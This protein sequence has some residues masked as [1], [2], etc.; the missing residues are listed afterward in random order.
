MAQKT[1]KMHLMLQLSALSHQAFY[2]A[3]KVVVADKLEA[4]KLGKNL[5]KYV[6]L[7]YLYNCIICLVSCFRAV[8]RDGGCVR[9][10]SR[11]LRL[12]NK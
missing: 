5:L 3:N 8:R 4:L 10:I 9:E 12:K 1:P 11:A 6:T 2:G 7:K